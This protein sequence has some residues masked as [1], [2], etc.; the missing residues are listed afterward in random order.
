MTYKQTVA[1]HKP[2]LHS[3]NAGF[4]FTGLIT[5]LRNAVSIQIPVG[6]QDESGFHTG[7]KSATKE[8]KWPAAW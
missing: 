6:Y 4:S 2:W 1:I 3:G 5:K 8:S 7:V